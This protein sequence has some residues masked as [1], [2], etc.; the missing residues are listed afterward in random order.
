M[1]NGPLNLNTTVKLAVRALAS[2]LH[3]SNRATSRAPD[4]IIRSQ[5]RALLIQLLIIRLLQFSSCLFFFQY[6]KQF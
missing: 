4:S 3:D 5:D 6:Y 2:A 1:Q